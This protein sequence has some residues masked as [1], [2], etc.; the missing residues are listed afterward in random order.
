MLIM[1]LE[2]GIPVDRVLYADVGTMAEFKS[3]YAY[4]AKL[5]AYTGIPIETVHS[6][7]WTARSMFYGYPSKGN[8][9][10]EIRGFPKT[11]GPA[12][13]YRSW[14][15]VDPLEKAAGQ[16]HDIFIGIAADEAGRSRCREYAKGKNRYHFPLVEWGITEQQ[17][18]DYLRE[19][20]LYSP[21]YDHFRR[22]GCF[23]CPK[24]PVGSLR[25]LYLHF[26]ELWATLRQ[27]EQ[28]QGR[29]FQYQ[30]TVADLERR[31]QAETQKN[32]KAV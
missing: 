12:C 16:G 11:I 21:L 23:W 25:Q 6:D 8:H 3:Q 24:Q 4:I 10:D 19:R 7:R 22:L 13:R 31:F 30:R 5:S 26:P 28:D 17:C 15:K 1:M 20:G 9:M 32:E 27:M 2:R 29:P 18:L 14:L